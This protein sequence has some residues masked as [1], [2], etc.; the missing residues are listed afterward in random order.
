MVSQITRIS[1]AATA[2]ARGG[3]IVRVAAIR[4]DDEDVIAAADPAAMSLLGEG[5]AVGRR[6]PDLALGA[7]AT[8]LRTLLARVRGGD[9]ALRGE[10]DLRCADG[11]VMYTAILAVRSESRSGVTAFLH[12]IS[13]RR[14]TEQVLAATQ[15]M[16]GAISRAQ[17]PARA[18]E[19]LIDSLGRSM[20]WAVGGYWTLA[21]DD[22]TL[23]LLAGW[24]AAGAEATALVAR[25]FALADSV[26]ERA[27]AAGEA[28]WAS[29]L[30]R[31]HMLTRS[32]GPREG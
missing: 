16:I 14:S 29:D 24:S 11:L 8:A 27:F 9:E 10:F 18:V 26:A 17:P 25:R 4:L 3:A 1:P 2:A 23:E 32:G 21:A 15:A 12:D 20:G 6:L 5:A 7:D 31:G 30:R 13:S 19:S 28:V 22:A